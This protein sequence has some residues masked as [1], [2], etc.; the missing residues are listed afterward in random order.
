MMVT[1]DDVI[2][3]QMDFFSDMDSLSIEVVPQR[4]ESKDDLGN[5]P[6]YFI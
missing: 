4:T 1:K 3:N 5:L 6:D 2:N